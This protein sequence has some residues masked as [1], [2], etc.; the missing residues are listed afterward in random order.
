VRL[1]A[2]GL[3]T[4]WGDGVAA[5]PHDSRLAAA[6]RRAIPVVAPGLDGERFRR[7]TRECVLGVA[8]V[9]ATLRQAGLGRAAI[10]GE[11]TALI[12]ATAAAYGASNCSFIAAAATREGAGALDFPYTAPSAVAAE[13]AIEF[14]LTG[15]FIILIGGGTATIEALWQAERL[16]AEGTAQR[17]LVLAVETFVECADLFARARWLAGVPLV[18]AA[19]CALL[20]PG[21]PALTA[22]PAAGAS[23]LEVQVR[24]RVG[25]TFACGPLIGL[26]LARETGDDSWSVTGHWRG[27]R[28]I[29]AR[30]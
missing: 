3:L 28:A 15:P 8:A 1:T 22:R 4:G 20:H 12:Y 26:A 6:G 29:L 30:C 10:A 24:R 18:E 16:L 2:V 5:L 7:A 21:S 25:E 14:G 19:V 13:V 9:H 11:G 17:A 27:R 23:A